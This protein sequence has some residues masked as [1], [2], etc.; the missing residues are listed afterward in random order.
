MF[1]FM[2]IL[3]A[4]PFIGIG[5]SHEVHQDKPAIEQNVNER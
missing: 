2:I 4:A 3:V 1:I 5:I